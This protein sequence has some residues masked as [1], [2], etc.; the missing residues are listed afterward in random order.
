MNRRGTRAAQIEMAS[1]TAATA[2]ES[3]WAA[4][5]F[6]TTIAS[7]I[8]N[9]S[10]PQTRPSR[11]A[12]ALSP[13][14]SSWCGFGITDPIR[15]RPRMTIRQL[16]ISPNQDHVAPS[17]PVKDDTDVVESRSLS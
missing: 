1:A 16:G 5:V 4:G 12:D 14:L 15:R 7:A 8:R 6:G 2:V 10:S 9:S 17:E 11:G 13:E 3:D